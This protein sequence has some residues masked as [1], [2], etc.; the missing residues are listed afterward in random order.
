MTRSAFSAPVPEDV[1]LVAKPLA[2]GYVASR[3]A[4]SADSPREIV[5]CDRSAHC[6]VILP[7]LL[8]NLSCTRT[9]RGV[10]KLFPN[11]VERF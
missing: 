9:P 2:P 11:R 5:E 1:Q 4:D 8:S 10:P 3:S 6:P 7:G